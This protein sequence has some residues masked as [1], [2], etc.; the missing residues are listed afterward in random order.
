[1]QSAIAF[2]PG[3]AI[4]DAFEGSIENAAEVGMVV[5]AA[6][7]TIIHAPEAG[8]R[9]VT[10]IAAERKVEIPQEHLPS[11]VRWSVDGLVLAAVVAV[12][13]PIADGMAECKGG[14]PDLGVNEGFDLLSCYGVPAARWQSATTIDQCSTAAREIGFPVV[15]KVDAETVVHK[16]DS[17]GVVL[18]LDDELAL[19]QQAENLAARFAESAPRF[20]VQEQVPEGIEVI[21]GAKK[22]ERLGHVIMFGLGGI[23]VEVLKDVSFKITPV[24]QREASE[25]LESLQASALL[26]GVRGQAGADLAALAEIIQRVSQM[27][28]DNPEIRELDINPVFAFERGAKAADVRVMIG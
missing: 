5:H 20:L 28:T 16:S 7:D 26:K 23:Y 17:G 2:L 24:T 1:M 25:M 11:A 12:A 19:Q 10:S 21:V 4:D 14:E 13:V 6:D 15:L 9:A 3:A 8:G 22:V 18:N 27:L